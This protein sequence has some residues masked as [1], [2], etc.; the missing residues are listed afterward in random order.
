MT[1][2]ETDAE[3]RAAAWDAVSRISAPDSSIDLGYIS[4]SL[5][6]SDKGGYVAFGL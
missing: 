2:H 1:F 3:A 4:V 5:P 6:T